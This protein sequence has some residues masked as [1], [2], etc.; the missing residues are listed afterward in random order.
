MVYCYQQVRVVEG[1]LIW[2]RPVERPL[3]SPRERACLA[4][5]HYL[6]IQNVWGQVCMLIQMQEEW[7][8]IVQETTCKKIREIQSVLPCCGVIGIS[9]KVLTIA[10]QSYLLSILQ[11]DHQDFVQ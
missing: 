8:D 2:Q 11:S 6:R 9:S 7:V 3:K 5:L 4:G 1:R 10:T